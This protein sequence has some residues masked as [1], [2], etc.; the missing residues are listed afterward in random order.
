MSNEAKDLL[1]DKISD[2]IIE[3]CA[4]CHSPEVGEQSCGDEGWTVCQD[5]QSIEQGYSDAIERSNLS[6]LE[7]SAA[8]SAGL[9]D[10]LVILD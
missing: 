1:A 8:D 3:V 5:C 7:F 6:D 2:L 9:L 4:V 10:G